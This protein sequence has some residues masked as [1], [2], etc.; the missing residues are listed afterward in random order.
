MPVKVNVEF[1]FCK[2]HSLQPFYGNKTDEERMDVDNILSIQDT[3]KEEN[4]I[5]NSG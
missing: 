4:V 5:F 1:L 3:I 2:A